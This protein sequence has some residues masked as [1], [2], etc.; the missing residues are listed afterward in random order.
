MYTIFFS[1]D[2]GLKMLT[3]V[4]KQLKIC[5]FLPEVGAWMVELCHL[6]VVEAGC[7]KVVV[8]VVVMACLPTV[9]ELGCLKDLV[10]FLF[11]VGDDLKVV[12]SHPSVVEAG[13]LKVV[14]QMIIPVCKPSSQSA[15]KMSTWQLAGSLWSS[16]ER[17]TIEH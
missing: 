13:C 1:D 3:I 7:L 10:C 2:E 5:L 17:S 6:S 15:S 8:V 14:E 12:V 11:V 9:V 4:S 16:F